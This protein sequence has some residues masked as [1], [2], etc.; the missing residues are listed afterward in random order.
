MTRTL[1]CP[2]KKKNVKWS[3]KPESRKRVVDW[4]LKGWYLASSGISV[5][6]HLCA[7]SCVF[8]CLLIDSG[9]KRNKRQVC[10]FAQKLNDSNQLT[11]ACDLLSQDI[12]RSKKDIYIYIY[13]YICPC[14][15]ICLWESVLLNCIMGR[16][17]LIILY[18]VEAKNASA[19]SFKSACLCSFSSFLCFQM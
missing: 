6:L 2:L 10:G 16:V 17:R 4:F 19:A 13:K 8:L 1:N 15:A 12:W 18:S 7:L 14:F 3:L 9:V 11:L 5:F